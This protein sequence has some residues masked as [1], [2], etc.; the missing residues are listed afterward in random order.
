VDIL[1]NLLLTSITA[2]HYV[3]KM[4]QTINILRDCSET[5]SFEKVDL[6]SLFYRYPQDL[7]R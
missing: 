4:H 6:L 5:F 7:I 3:L 2:A 1:L